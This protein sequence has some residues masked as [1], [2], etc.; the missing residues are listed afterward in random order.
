MVKVLCFYHPD[1]DAATRAA[2]EDQVVRLADAARGNGLEFLLEIIPS[3]VAP[4]DSRTT[5][6]AIRRFY[7]AGVRPDAGGIP[8]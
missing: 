5:A 8:P 6:T 4:C 3:A 7:E 1:D 2:Q